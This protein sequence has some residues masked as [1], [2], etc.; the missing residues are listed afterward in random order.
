MDP[1][2]NIEFDNPFPDTI[3]TTT[4]QEFNDFMKSKNTKFLK[5]I[6]QNIALT[7]TLWN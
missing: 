7:K 2:A 4:A 5:I 6:H 3:S 1:L